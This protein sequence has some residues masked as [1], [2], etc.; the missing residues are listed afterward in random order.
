MAM[1]DWLDGA[2]R[3][4]MLYNHTAKYKEAEAVA[5]DTAR[6]ALLALYIRVPRQLEVARRWEWARAASLAL[7]PS[8][9]QHIL[10]LAD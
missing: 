3:S 10:E 1:W 7:P 4:I 6:Q 5:R 8:L 2:A 9:L